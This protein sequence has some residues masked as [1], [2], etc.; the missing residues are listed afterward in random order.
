[1]VLYHFTFLRHRESIVAEGLRPSDDVVWL[2]TDSETIYAS[3]Q[4]GNLLEHAH[5]CRIKLVIPSHDRRLIN[6]GR[7]VRKRG[8]REEVEFYLRNPYLGPER[9]RRTVQD[10]HCYLGTVPPDYFREIIEISH[11]NT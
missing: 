5:D 1:M 8:G 4:Y 10:W 3:D 7:L 9:A 6:W 11:P 2:T